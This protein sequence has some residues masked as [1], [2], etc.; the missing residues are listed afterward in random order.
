[1]SET[2]HYDPDNHAFQQAVSFVNHTAR[3][4]F[5]TGKAGTGKT[6]FLKY[7][8]QHSHKNMVI[9]APTGV[10]AINAGGTT[11][12]ALFQLP[13]GLYLH[14]YELAWNESDNHIYNR[15]RLLGQ[16]RF[17]QER[18]QLLQ[19]LELLIIDEVSMLRADALDAV[20]AILRSIRRS[21][22]PYGGVQVLFIGDLFQLPPVTKHHEMALM[23]RYYQSPFFFEALAVKQSPPI[24]L[25]LDKIYRQSDLTFIELL[26]NVRDNCCT[27]EQL[28]LLNQRHIP[29]FV[30]TKGESYITL[31]SHNR[32]ADAI[33][34][35]ELDKLPDKEYK[36]EA[37]IK[38]EFSNLTFPTESTL[39]LK[40]G[41]QVMF[42]KNDKGEER[43]YYNG[44]I[45]TIT[46]ISRDGK[47]Q[48]RFEGEEGGIEVE[49][50]KWENIRYSYDQ[51]EDKIESETLGIFSQYPIRL[52]WAVTIHKSQ[53]LTF[54]RA[55]IDAGRSFAP[56]QVYVAL[57]RLTN[58]EGLVLS[59]PITSISIKSDQQV[60][61]F[62][63]QF[64]QKEQVDDLLQT[65]QKYFLAR[66]LLETFSFSKLC[67]EAQ[68]L[69][70]G[71]PQKLAVDRKLAQE[72][73]APL[74]RHCAEM[75]QVGDK[76]KTWLGKRFEHDNI[77]YDEIHE[78]TL[79]AVGWFKEEIDRQ[80]IR[81]FTE[82]SKL[83][84]STKKNK[85]FSK[86]IN[87]LLISLKRKEAQIKHSTSITE[88]L[89]SGKNLSSVLQDAA[90]TKRVIV[91]IDEIGISTTSA[92]KGDS[93]QISLTL[94]KEG[95]T[96]QEIAKERGFAEST[97]M[98]HLI[99]FLGTELEGKDLIPADRLEKLLTELKA[100][101]AEQ[102]L[103][104]IK[105]QLHDE[106][107]YDEL[108]IAMKTLNNQ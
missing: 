62:S 41:A 89:S 28:N 108:R 55:I 36:F 101:S 27:R 18:R 82:Q 53:G 26:N 94:F 97:I 22:L 7:I 105:N 25:Q 79:K 59:S 15:R 51:Q 102:S 76:F 20:D 86:K 99:G 107:S 93:K 5:L 56:G 69:L 83:W 24:M 44:K 106:Y 72:A 74:A 2:I 4:I 78:R 67:R 8:R 49:R 85:A 39:I 35:R 23:Q 95:K 103:S 100:F 73:L 68:E 63:K 12:H 75:L 11:L 31:T 3:S 92:K 46:D 13:F 71:A 50:E 48:V 65:E 57:S 1:M 87:S 58:M 64:L 91:P 38:G 9:V 81:P 52:A 98:S 45:G 34:Q 30:P 77:D 88:A 10:A 14:D 16:L 54:D 29:S 17:S 104:A 37:E 84:A 21:A 43:R 80:L 90:E 42:I 19:E 66:N 60:L 32:L 40:K 6:T 61:A 33:N 96:I 47:I 70:Q